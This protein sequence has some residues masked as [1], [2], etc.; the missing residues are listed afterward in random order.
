MPG[1]QVTTRK[2]GEALLIEKAQTD[3]G[4]RRELIANP[5]STISKTLGVALPPGLAITVLEESARQVY[6]VLP[7]MSVG[8]ELSDDELA[9]VAGGMEAEAKDAGTMKKILGE[10]S[11]R[12]TDA[13]EIAH[14]AQ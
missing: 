7:A 9:T 3:Q 12:A 10:K 5:S 8:T 4:F 1:T 14:R 6:L 2:E 13:A 11:A